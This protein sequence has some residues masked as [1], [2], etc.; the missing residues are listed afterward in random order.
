MGREPPP[1]GYVLSNKAA[2]VDIFVGNRKPLEIRLPYLDLP[3]MDLDAPGGKVDLND[4]S[5]DPQDWLERIE[6]ANQKIAAARGD[7]GV[8]YNRLEHAAAS[9]GTEKI[10]LT[11]AE[12]RLR[13]TDMAK[14]IVDHTK[15]KVL[16]QAQQ[17]MLA[18]ANAQS[19]NVIRMLK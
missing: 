19:G 6:A 12:S 5:Q 16:L 4:P 18:Q 11:D 1:E 14:E 17:S 10:N 7:I 2:P 15:L 13:D 3:V 9:I 8:D